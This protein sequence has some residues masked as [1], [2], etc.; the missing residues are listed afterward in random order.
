MDCGW[1]LKGF[2]KGIGILRIPCKK[3]CRI[4]G[5]DRTVQVDF[6]GFTGTGQIHDF[7]INI[8][9]VFGGQS[10]NHRIR[11]HYG[12]L[13][14]YTVKITVKT[15]VVCDNL[16]MIILP[17]TYGKGGLRAKAAVIKPVYRCKFSGS[18]FNGPDIPV[19]IDGVPGGEERIGF[20]SGKQHG[21]AVC[22]NRNV[23][24]TGWGIKHYFKLVCTAGTFLFPE[25]NKCRIRRNISCIRVPA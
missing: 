14:Q 25:C 13:Y 5:F 1:N 12:P 18:L 6:Y 24:F 10:W 23:N 9:S 4:S 15:A 20:I 2:I 16:K 8:R 3:R 17:I 22:P 21:C 19:G 7:N 11:H